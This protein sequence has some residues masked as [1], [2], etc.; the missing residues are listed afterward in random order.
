MRLTVPVDQPIHSD[1]R[2]GVQLI[3][4][5]FVLGRLKANRSGFPRK[6][7]SCFVFFGL[8]DQRCHSNRLVRIAFFQSVKRA[9]RIWLAT[10]RRTSAWVGYG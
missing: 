10:L 7:V 6:H 3:D 1:E 2:H 4:D 5:S 9:F 8:S